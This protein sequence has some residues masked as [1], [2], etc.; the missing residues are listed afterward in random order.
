MFHSEKKPGLSRALSHSLLWSSS[1]I[2]WL[3]SIEVVV[4]ADTERMVTVIAPVHLREC[5]PAAGSRATAYDCV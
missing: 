1:V 4:Q 5:A 3:R 2:T